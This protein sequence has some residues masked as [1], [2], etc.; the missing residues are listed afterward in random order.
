MF[1]QCDLAMGVL[2]F[3]GMMFVRIHDFAFI[4]YRGKIETGSLFEEELILYGLEKKV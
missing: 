4:I 1:R 3:V 2:F